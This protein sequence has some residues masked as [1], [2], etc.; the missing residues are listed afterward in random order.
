MTTT[1]VNERDYTF[2]ADEVGP[3]PPTDASA[4]FTVMA[5]RQ[6]LMALKLSCRTLKHAGAGG[7]RSSSLSALA[8]PSENAYTRLRIDEQAAGD[9]ALRND[10]DDAEEAAEENADEEEE[11]QEDAEGEPDDEDLLDHLCKMILGRMALKRLMYC[12]ECFL[13]APPPPVADL[14]WCLWW[15]A[16][17]LAV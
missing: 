10:S 17:C 6:L 2:C 12:L 7:R 14:W 1:G 16:C 4:L 13:P 9:C 3:W 8:S 5:T 15:V 11:E